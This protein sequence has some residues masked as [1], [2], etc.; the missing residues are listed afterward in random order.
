[1]GRT[2]KLMNTTAIFSPRTHVHIGF[3]LIELMIAITLSMMIAYT[4]FAAFRVASQ[5]V[6]T[7]RRLSIENGMMRTGFIAALEELDFWDLYDDRNAPNPS[8][9]PL[10]ATGKPFCPMSYDPTRKENDPRTWWRGFG[11]STDVANTNLWGNY[12]LLSK[13]GHSDAVRAWYPNQVKNFSEKL[14]AYGM[15]SYLPG[16]AIFCWYE[17]GSPFSIK[18]IPRDIWERTA[19]DPLTV[20]GDAFEKG[21]RLDHLPSRP[22]H[23]PGLSVETRRYAIWSSYIDL[24]QVEVTSP[25]TGETARLSFWGVGTSLRGARQQRSLDTVAIK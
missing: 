19:W 7:C 21:N 15:I 8:A 1:M 11:F 3:T 18:G 10:R 2:E 14:G 5:S 6:A 16:D 24:C 25:I 9:N 13:A 17:N 12:S 4:A 23:W 22:S 20:N